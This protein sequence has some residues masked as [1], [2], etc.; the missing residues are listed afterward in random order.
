MAESEDAP[1]PAAGRRLLRIAA[2]VLIGLV[3][4]GVALWLVRVG[5]DGV[6]LAE[7]AGSPVRGFWFGTVLAGIA[8]LPVGGWFLVRRGGALDGVFLGAAAWGVAVVAT[9]AGPGG[10]RDV[11]GWNAL[12]ESAPAWLL[13]ET[14]LLWITATL[15]GTRRRTPR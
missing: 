15:R 3:A 11:E 13:G 5:V 2:G 1:G 9:V 7:V 4:A 6:G 12:L 14:F 8:W 10:G